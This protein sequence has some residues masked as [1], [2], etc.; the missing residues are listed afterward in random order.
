M[1]CWWARVPGPGM[2][3]KDLLEANAA[4]FRPKVRR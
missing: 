1:R 4:S 2:E 3:R